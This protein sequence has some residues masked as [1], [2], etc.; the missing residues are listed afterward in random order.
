MA[1]WCNQ[2]KFP[3][4]QCGQHSRL[5]GL[6]LLCSPS[7]LAPSFPRP[8]DSRRTGLLSCPRAHALDCSSLGFWAALNL[9]NTTWMPPYQRGL[10]WLLSLLFFLTKS[11]YCSFMTHLTLI[12]NI[13]VI[14]CLRSTS[15]DTTHFLFVCL[16]CMPRG[17]GGRKQGRT[18]HCFPQLSSTQLLPSKNSSRS[19]F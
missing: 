12:T 5:H 8:P 10:C 19:W 9:Q 2:N 3:A 18:F 7:R 11:S 1:S 16:Q 13:F 15:P 14:I 17:K 4:L 6:A